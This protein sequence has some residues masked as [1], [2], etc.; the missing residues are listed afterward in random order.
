MATYKVAAIIV[1]T[2]LLL[3]GDGISS[4]K[5]G[6]AEIRV[7]LVIGNGRYR[8]DPL[9]NPPRDARLIADTLTRVGFDVI[10]VADADRAT[11]QS[12]LVAFSRKLDQAGAVG[13]FYYA[14]HGV[15]VAGVNYLLPVDV[16]IRTEAEVLLQGINLKE[17]LKTL[18]PSRS[19]LTVAVLDACRNNPF[20]GLVRGLRRGLAPVTAPAGT[21]IAFSTA[22]GEVALDGDGKN[23]PYTAALANVIPAPGLAIEEVFKRTRRKVMQATGNAQVPWE[24]SSLIGRFSFSPESGARPDSRPNNHYD[25]DADLRLAEI[26]AWERIKHANDIKRYQEFL[27]RFPS[28]AFAE[29]AQYKLDQLGKKPSSWSWWLPKVVTAVRPR[30]ATRAQAEELFERALRFEAEQ[31]SPE[32]VAHA[33]TLYKAAAEAGLAPAMFRLAR[34][35]ERQARAKHRSG[36]SGMALEA[37]L[38]VA[39][40]WYAKGAEQSHPP[41]QSALG[42]LYEFGEGVPKNLIEAL[43]LYRISA[44]AGDASGMTSLGFLYATGKGVARDPRQGRNWYARAAN[45]GSVRAMFNFAIMLLSQDGG[46][47]NVPEAAKWLKEAAKQGHAGAMRQLAVLYDQ[48]R[49]LP[50][51]SEEAARLLLK[52]HA[53]GDQ[54]AKSD[55][56]KHYRRWSRATRREVQR[57]L[58][59]DGLYRGA[60][61]G[62]FNSSTRRALLVHAKR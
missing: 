5:P 26:N 62:V 61:H 45:A 38:K 31:K 20:S 1:A 53:G 9:A 55:L 36:G 35:I 59:A 30:E 41:S 3:V 2:L 52:A 23:S 21:L 49:G 7:A 48:G 10:H 29:L 16:D 33:V 58:R 24:H 17:I 15:Q 46:A 37:K 14:G 11:M 44:K 6:L 43:R 28:G 34:L 57:Q 22:P 39:A 54:A 12:V 42:T 56:F 25:I 13:L 40:G 27:Q 19:R 4:A 51:N 32:D 47:M 18:R 50:R 8:R 60:I